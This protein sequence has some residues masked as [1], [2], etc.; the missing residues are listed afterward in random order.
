MDIVTIAVIVMVGIVAGLLARG[1]YLIGQGSEVEME[2][3][4]KA[5]DSNIVNSGWMILDWLRNWDSPTLQ[6]IESK[7]G[8]DQEDGED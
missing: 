4:S 8:I 2:V 7:L 5:T 3:R 1:M 6:Y